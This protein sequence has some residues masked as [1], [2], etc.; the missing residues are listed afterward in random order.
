M[1]MMDI[2]MYG[3]GHNHHGGS[4][5]PDS[6]FYNYTEP[7]GQHSSVHYPT[8]YQ[9]EEQQS[10]LYP[11]SEVPETPPSP[12]DL[13]YYTQQVHPDNPIINTE[14]GL[15]YTNLDYAHSSSM[16]PHNSYD[17]YQRDHQD[18]LLRHHEEASDN[19]VIHSYLGD[20][21]YHHLGHDVGYPQNLGSA[22]SPPSS[23]MEYQHLHRYKEEAVEVV[24]NRMK[25]NHHMH[26]LNPVP[27]QQQPSLPTYKWMQ[28]KRNVPK[29]AGKLLIYF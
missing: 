15:S 16:Y 18:I 12:N 22:R 1:M 7:A 14:T 29:P 13:N 2:G 27:T 21:K 28:V 26:S 6:N 9:Y 10:F 11:T 4:Y 8:S 25:Q 17:P 19:N 23:C 24:D 5:N 3:H 20:N